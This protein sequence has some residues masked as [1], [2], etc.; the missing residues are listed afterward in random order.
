[1]LEA[2]GARREAQTRPSRCCVD[3]EQQTRALLECDGAVRFVGGACRVL[4]A[5][6][7]SAAKP[8]S[9]GEQLHRR[10]FARV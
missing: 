2:R 6:G 9:G 1:M 4:E 10:C 8:V 3:G 5:R 7:A